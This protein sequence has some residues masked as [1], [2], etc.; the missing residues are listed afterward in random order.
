MGTDL[1][2]VWF[3]GSGWRCDGV[4]ERQRHNQ[5]TYSFQKVGRK[6]T[7]LVFLFNE[8]ISERCVKNLTVLVKV[9]NRPIY[10]RWSKAPSFFF[11]LLSLYQ[12]GEDLFSLLSQFCS[13]IQWIKKMSPD[14]IQ[15]NVI[16]NIW[17]C[18]VTY[19]SEWRTSFHLIWW[20]GAQCLVHATSVF[21]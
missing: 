14:W 13:G 5:G 8:L 18:T 3:D 10:I 4:N 15:F 21:H 19:C 17:Q 7:N 6:I 16:E 11:N 9:S 12:V 20:R 2:G 1:Y